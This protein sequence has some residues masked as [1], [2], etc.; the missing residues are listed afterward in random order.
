MLIGNEECRIEK[1]F[2]IDI[3]VMG[4]SYSY[5]TATLL[6]RALKFRNISPAFSLKAFTFRHLIVSIPNHNQLLSYILYFT[7][8]RSLLTN[9]YNLLRKVTSVLK[10]SLTLPTLMHRVM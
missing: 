3:Y 8:H 9:I 10:K 7:L 4:I 2:P 5:T 6:L 1:S